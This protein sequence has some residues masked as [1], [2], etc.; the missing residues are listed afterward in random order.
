MVIHSNQHATNGG[1]QIALAKLAVRVE[2]AAEKMVP[3][4]VVTVDFATDFSS[5]THS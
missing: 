3:C 1:T 5:C 2:L 4:F